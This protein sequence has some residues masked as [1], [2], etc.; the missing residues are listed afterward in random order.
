MRYRRHFL[1]SWERLCWVEKDGERGRVKITKAGKNVL[2]IFY[3][4]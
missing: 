3:L 1:D 2:N 4:D